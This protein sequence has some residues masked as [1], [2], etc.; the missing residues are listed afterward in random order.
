MFT[1]VDENHPAAAWFKINDPLRDFDRIRSLVSQGFLV[2]TRADA[3]T[4]NARANDT[5]QRDQALASGAQFVSTD[6]AE[7]DRRFS[8]YRVGFPRD[9]SARLN[10][11]SGPPGEPGLELEIKKSP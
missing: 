5:R 10:P 3:N 1:T 8:E 4:V 9:A 7:P 6:Y 2:R 11:V